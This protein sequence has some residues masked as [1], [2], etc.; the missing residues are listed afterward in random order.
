[1]SANLSLVLL[2]PALG[3]VFGA[4]FLLLW[5]QDRSRRYV[6]LLAIVY[7][8]SAT[9]FLLHQFDLPVFG[10]SSRF[11]AQIA[12]MAAASLMVTA[13][14]QRYDRPAPVRLMALIVAAGLTGAL[15]FTL[16]RPDFS[17]RAYF[18]TGGIG[19]LLMLAAYQI[20]ARSTI[21]RVL[22]ALI[23]LNGATMALRSALFM[24]LAGAIDPD[25]LSQSPA[26]I[27]F[28]FS[29]S[30]TSLMVASTLALAV[31]SDLVGELSRSSD[32][33]VLSELLNRR[34]FEKA[35]VAH[36]DRR[37][38]ASL[39]LCDLDYFK[40]INDRFGHQTGDRVIAIFGR[41]LADV[42]G[43]SHPVGRI[44]GEEFAIFLCG[45][46]AAVA[47]TVALGV[48]AAFSQS[49]LPLLDAGESDFTASFGVAEWRQTDTY[50]DLLGRAD[51]ALYNAKR[52]GRNQVAVDGRPEE[53]CSVNEISARRLA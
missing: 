30:I 46:N 26:W 12:F 43:A 16:I 19:A 20:R 34:G 15:W 9:G 50:E 21:D 48:G 44:G 3:I 47:R 31:V 36:A 32:T 33:D 18:I 5:R 28:V 22:M 27:G 38:P 7:F 8:L 45:A 40:D 53:Q 17:G 42:V 49:V 24:H 23:G 29:H 4:V 52:R 2:N 11:L 6:L 41:I 39:I 51:R 37:L 14:S 1:M 25:A 13:I 35:V 10:H